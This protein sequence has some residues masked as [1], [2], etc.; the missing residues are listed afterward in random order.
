MDNGNKA[1]LAV[2]VGIML[3]ILGI[4]LAFPAL[5]RYTQRQDCIAVGR[6]NC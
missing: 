2:L 5:T 4:W 1:A 6:T 3:V